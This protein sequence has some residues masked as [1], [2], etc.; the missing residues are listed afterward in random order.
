MRGWVR[1]LGAGAV[2]FLLIQGFRPSIPQRPAAAEIQVPSQ[3]HAILARDCYACHSDERRLAWFDEVQPAYGL[4]RKDILAARAR[5]NFSTI[6]SQPKAVQQGAL[7]E[8]VAM[9]QLGVMPLDRYARLHTEARV[10]SEDL[11][12]LKN[13]L[14]PWSSPIPRA[15]EVGAERSIPVSTGAPAVRPVLNG[16]EYDASWREWKLL[17]VT[18]RGDNR[19]FRMIVGN[20]IAV[21]AAREGKVRPWPDGARFAKVAWLQEQTPDGLIVPG[22]FFQVELM[23]KGAEKY[24][25]TEG[26][27]WGRWRGLDL[28]PYGKDASFV[29]ECTGCHLPMRGNDYVYSLPFSR[30]RV[31]GQEVL[32][33]T[34]AHFPEGLSSDPL[35]WTPVTLYVDPRAFTISVLFARDADKSG[36]EMALVTWKER[37]DPHWFGARMADRVVSVETRRSRFIANL[38]PVQAP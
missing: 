19:Q 10:S 29:N 9:M 25:S 31:S 18:D 36:S 6:G 32:N 14:L 33:N 7:Y 21:A 4:V 27:G 38:H 20:D 37:D 26:W 24:R 17:A 11:E 1:V 28:K 22:K 13:Y 35:N 3:V 12:T 30:A 5:L 16:L 8:S 34:G 2:L 15:T 23:V